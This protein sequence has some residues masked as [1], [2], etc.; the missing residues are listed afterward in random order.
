MMMVLF[1]VR[2]VSGF[3]ADGIHLPMI[4]NSNPLI[5][6]LD[7]NRDGSSGYMGISKFNEKNKQV[8]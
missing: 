5:T 2:V 7:T 4:L 1:N 8:I 3:V 6:A